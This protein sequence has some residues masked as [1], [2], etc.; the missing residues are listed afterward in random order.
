MKLTPRKAVIELHLGDVEFP[1][2]TI[3]KQSL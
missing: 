3:Q 2:W 1:L